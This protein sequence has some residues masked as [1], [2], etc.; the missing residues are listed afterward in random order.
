MQKCET[1]LTFICP[2]CKGIFQFDQVEEYQL[3][4]CPICGIDFITVRR[5]QKIVLENAE[6]ENILMTPI[7]D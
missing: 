7:G 5:N 3:V 4:P 6:L 1:P 2:V